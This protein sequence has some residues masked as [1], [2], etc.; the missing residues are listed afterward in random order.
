MSASISVETRLW[1]SFL[2]LETAYF[3]QSRTLGN[4]FSGLEEGHGSFLYIGKNLS[5]SVRDLASTLR[6][7]LIWQNLVL[8]GAYN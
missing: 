8:S 4:N 7:C 6:S 5:L 1:Y 3:S 2:V